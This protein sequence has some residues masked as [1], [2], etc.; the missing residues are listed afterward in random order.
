[1]GIDRRGASFWRAATGTWNG[2]EAAFNALPRNAPLAALPRRI[3]VVVAAVTP[4]RLAVRHASVA[5]W[6]AAGAPLVHCL[7]AEPTM[8][9]WSDDVA[10]AD[11]LFADR[12]LAERVGITI[13]EQ[14]DAIEIERGVVRVELTT[15][16]FG[17]DYGA[18]CSA[19]RAAALIIERMKIP[20]PEDGKLPLVQFRERMALQLFPNP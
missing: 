4:T 10:F 13:H 20:A 14:G 2:R 9:V 8:A 5:L 3:E 1:M 16:R 12:E 19:W 18:Y 6:Y 15:R 11:R 17:G 7:V